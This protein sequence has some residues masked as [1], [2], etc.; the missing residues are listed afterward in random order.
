MEA[1]ALLSD[2]R[3]SLVGSYTFTKDALVVPGAKTAKLPGFEGATRAPTAGG[4][5]RSAC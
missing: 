5:C 4:A 2:G 1:N 3:C